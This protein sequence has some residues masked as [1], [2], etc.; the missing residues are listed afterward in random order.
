MGEEEGMDFYDIKDVIVNYE[1]AAGCQDPPVCV[2]G[3][4]VY[5]EC[6]CYCPQG[7][8]GKTCETVITDSDCGGM[9]EVPPD[10]DVFVISPGYP[11]S[12]P[13]GKTCRWGVKAPKGWN[14][15]MTV[16]ELR[17]PGNS[18]NR[19]YNWLEI[20]YNLPGQRGIKRCGEMNGDQWTGSKDSPDFMTLTFNSGIYYQTSPLQ[21]FRLRFNAIERKDDKRSQDH[22]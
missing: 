8:T 16:E 21:G 13:P 7:Y 17:L 10:N 12:Y 1:C 6:V 20:Q 3:G 14:I 18:L 2:N 19:C 4:F 22:I 5:H 11:A 15:R 9:V